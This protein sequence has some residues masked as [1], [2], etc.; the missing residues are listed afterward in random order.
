MTHPFIRPQPGIL[1]IAP[2]KGGE[3]RLPGQAKALKL[4]SNEN[5]HG[6]SPDAVAAFRDTRSGSRSI[7]TA[8]M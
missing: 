6:P 8:R 2:Y 3:A 7:R 5:P 4:S 1:D